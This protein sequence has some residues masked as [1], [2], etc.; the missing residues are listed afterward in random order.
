MPLKKPLEYPSLTLPKD[1][2]LD[3]SLV[4]RKNQGGETR[5]QVIDRSETLYHVKVSSTGPEYKTTMDE[6]VFK[7]LEEDLGQLGDSFDPNGEGMGTKFNPWIYDFDRSM[8]HMIIKESKVVLTRKF[9]FYA[10]SHL[11]LYFIV[12]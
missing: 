5:L 12:Q 2:F 9:E 3:N 7:A 6:L 4:P 11:L 8:L 1:F 10:F